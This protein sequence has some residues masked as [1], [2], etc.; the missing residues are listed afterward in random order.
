MREELDQ[1]AERIRQLTLLTQQLR[2]ENKDLRL[3]NH[4]L[5]QKITLAGTRV[6][7]ILERLPDA[8]ATAL[9]GGA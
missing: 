8:A 6:Q 4:A 3:Q 9:N 2:Q 7:S 5:E 1:L